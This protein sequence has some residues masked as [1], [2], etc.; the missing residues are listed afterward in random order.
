MLRANGIII[1]TE[2]VALESVESAAG[3]KCLI[4]VTWQPVTLELA[5]IRGSA[6]PSL[7]DVTPFRHSLPVKVLL[8][9]H[10]PVL[11]AGLLHRCMIRCSNWIVLW[12]A[13]DM[14]LCA[15]VFGSQ[16][17][18]LTTSRITWFHHPHHQ[19]GHASIAGR[20]LGSDDPT[21]PTV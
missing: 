1:S 7:L 13:F 15:R 18:R 11:L 14:L 12:M 21:K 4:N 8:A 6:L 3:K 20:P 10:R 17:S 19:M 2:G 9:I 16:F 5:D